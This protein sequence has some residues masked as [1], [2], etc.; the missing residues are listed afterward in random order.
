MEDHPGI[1]FRDGP[2]GRRA[3]LAA[4]PDLWEVVGVL[5]ATGL[6]GEEALQVTAEWSSLSM[7][8]VREAIGYYN[9]YPAEIDARIRLHEDEADAAEERWRQQHPAG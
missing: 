1:V 7:R 5:R 9:E 8:Q 3:G 4:G 6:G 2:T